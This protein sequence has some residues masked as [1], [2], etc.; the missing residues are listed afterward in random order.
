MRI[1][2]RRRPSG[3]DASAFDLLEYLQ[4]SHFPIHALGSAC[5]IRGDFIVYIEIRCDPVVRFEDNI[6]LGSHT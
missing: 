2:K 5:R 3:D 1:L 4:E 6:P